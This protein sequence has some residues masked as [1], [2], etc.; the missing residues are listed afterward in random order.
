MIDR[1]KKRNKFYNRDETIIV[2]NK[3]R[4][5]NAGRQK[6]PLH[7]A[8]DCEDWEFVDFLH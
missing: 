7:E 2:S 4:L 3:S 8:I 6:L 5:I 1:A